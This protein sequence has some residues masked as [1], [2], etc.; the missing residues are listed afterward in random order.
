MSVILSRP[1][2][3]GCNFNAVG[4]PIVYQFR[5]EDYQFSQINNNGGDAQ[6]QID[7]IDLTTYF[8]VD[9]TVY[10]DGIGS[11]VITASSF[12][13]GN[14]L[15]TVDYTFSATATG[16]INDLS[17]RTDSK[18]EIEVFD[19]SGVALAPRL[20]ATPGENGEVKADISGIVKAFLQ[21][22]WENPTVNAEEAYTSKKVYIEYEDFYDATYQGEVSD[23]ANPVVCVF[24]IMHLLQSHP[25][26]FTR[27][28]H[29]GNML[30]FY[31]DD[32]SKLWLTKFN[33]S[34]WI[35]Y[36]FTLS[37]IWPATIT[38]IDRRVIQYDGEGNLLSDDLTSLTPETDTIHRTDLG[39]VNTSAK[40]LEVSLEESTSGSGQA[41]IIETLTINVK[42]PCEQPVLLFWKNSLG[43]DA[44]WLFDEGQDYNYQYPSGR[45]VKRMTLSA[46]NLTVSEWDGI[47]QLNS[48]SQV[49]AKNITDYGMDDSI[50]RTHF[51]NDNQVFIINSDGSKTGVIVIATD[52]RTKTYQKKH[53][54]EITIELPEFFTV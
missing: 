25:P 29:G 9:D 45:V 49:I 19:V 11:V 35:G 39:A 14:T 6:I 50:D 47:N 12:S 54:I 2:K 43:G 15:V 23:S 4:N 24:A 33:P 31:P 41:Q 13:G 22:D 5:R 38:G 52:N 27:Y 28:A 1:I 16:Y 34:Y 48:V 44:F 51:R 46:D 3:S 18:I 21:A 53:Y 8:E 40:R 32:D 36:P 10:V 26:N 30:S 17:K 20:I 37:F 7:G 42:E